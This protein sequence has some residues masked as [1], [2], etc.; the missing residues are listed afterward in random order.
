VAGYTRRNLL[1]LGL[2]FGLFLV[3]LAFV[4]PATI[5]PAFAAHLGASS[6]VIGAIPA[7]MTAGWFL[8]SLF[9]AGHTEAL[10]RK[11]PFVLRWTL[12]ERIPFLGLAAVAFFLAEPA[13]GWALAVMLGLL[14]VITGVGGLLMPAWM[15]IVGRAVPGGLRGRF[16]ALASGLGTGGGLV[17]SLA[18]AYVLAQVAPPASYGVCFLA[19]AVCMGL[20]YLALALVR[21][22]PGAPTSPAVPLTAYLARIPALI[23]RDRD[24]TWF[25]LART[26]AIVGT[27]ASGFLTVYALRAFEAPAWRAGVFT[28]WMVAGQLGG[29]LA[30]GWLADRVGHRL[31]LIAGSAAAVGANV[32]ALAAPSVEAFGA[33]FALLGVYMASTH[34]SGLTILLEF[35]PTVPERPTY[36]GIGNTCA[37]PA[38]LGAPHLAGVMVDA[39]GYAPVFALA[40]LPGLVGLAVLTGCVSDPRV[41]AAGP[42]G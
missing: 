23:R 4:S 14:L 15:D 22:P 24:L 3:G 34:V 33:A 13:S 31:V 40:T 32:V 17:A 9:A 26:C 29:N 2:D 16:F 35:A 21:E 8:P 11:L 20:S 28:T 30:L 10:P 7:I 18:T 12:W 27:M 5:L 37:A 6:L 25:L 1:T 41:R 19:S 39:L 42:R 38:A 36:V